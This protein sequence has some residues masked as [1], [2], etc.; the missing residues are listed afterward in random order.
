MKTSDPISIILNQL[1]SPSIFVDKEPTIGYCSYLVKCESGNILN[2]HFRDKVVDVNLYSCDSKLLATER[3]AVSN[4]TNAIFHFLK[5]AYNMQ[6]FEDL[7]NKAC[8]DREQWEEAV[9]AF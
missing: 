2:L 9:K 7:M 1:S 3:I 6:K 4:A 5:A 8:H